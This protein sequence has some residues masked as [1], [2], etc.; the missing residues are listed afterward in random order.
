MLLRNRGKRKETVSCR[1]SRPLQGFWSLQDSTGR[2]E[3]SIC[4]SSAPSLYP[5]P[6]GFRSRPDISA[7]CPFL[8]VLRLNPCRLH[9]NKLPLCWRSVPAP[10]SLFSPISCSSSGSACPPSPCLDIRYLETVHSRSKHL[11][12]AKFF[13]LDIPVKRR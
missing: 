2:G 1:K 5:R 10:R 13:C 11:C 7:S 3:T 12:R 9:R 8:R 4:N 6:R